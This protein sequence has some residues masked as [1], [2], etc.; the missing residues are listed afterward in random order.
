MCGIAGLIN[1]QASQYIEEFGEAI[2]HR[3]PDG[4]GVFIREGIGLASR[5]LAI[6]DLSPKGAQPMYSQDKRYVIV[7]NG[8]IYNHWDIRK[9]WLP[10]IQFNSSSD[11]ETLLYGYIKYGHDILNK[12]IGIFAFAIYDLDAKELFIARDQFGVKPLYYYHHEGTFLF[13]SEIKSF[14]D[15]PGLCR[16][17]D[18]RSLLHYISFLYSP[19]PSTPFLKVRKL[20]PG[21]F[22]RMNIQQ[23]DQLEIKKYYEIPFV[24]IY[25]NAAETELID[26]L[27]MRLR[28][29]VRRQLLSDVPVGFFLS[30]GLDSS[31]IVAMAKQELPG[32]RLKCFTIDD[33]SEGSSEG[34]IKDLPYAI[35]VAQYLN[36]DLEI[37]KAD[38]DILRDFNKMVWHLDEPQADAAPLNVLNICR[39]ARASGYVVLLSGAGGDDLFSGYRRHQMLYYHKLLSIIPKSFISVFKSV[40][41]SASV[42]RSGVRRFKKILET[43]TYFSRKERSAS[44]YLWL[45]FQIAISLLSEKHKQ[46]LRQ[47]KPETVLLDSLQNIPRE[48][49]ELNQMLYWELK[50]FLPDHN[51]NYTDKMSMAE[52]VEVRVPFLDKELVEFSTSIP[53]HLKMKGTTTKYILRKVAERY[54]PH[55]IIYRPKTGFGAP[56]RK[57]INQDLHSVIHDY[58]NSK[59]CRQQGLFDCDAVNKLLRENAQGKMDA[60]YP[61]LALLAINSWHTQFVENKTVTDKFTVR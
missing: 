31:L 5:R 37:V 36:V 58:F 13:G 4:D 54:L 33:L 29:A 59:K 47:F 12:L 56:V 9:E 39:Q 11:T 48:R 14:M 51:L 53:P 7:Y 17:L 41:A 30:G 61:I 46:K 27:D 52:G 42:K 40:I 57:W 20:E 1:S 24:G 15:F 60:S 23:V 34:F 21:H 25:S 18:I 26:E 43:Q 50:Y 10:E 32:S 28:L 2:S 49:N 35:K 8:E 45:P 6:Q 3:G 55:E 19:G 38:M 44:Y 22:I 16:D